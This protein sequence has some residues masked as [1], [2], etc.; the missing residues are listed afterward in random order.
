MTVSSRPGPKRLVPVLSLAFVALFAAACASASTQTLGGSALVVAA[1]PTAG[2]VPV[3]LSLATPAPAATQ[4]TV[5]SV[6][7]GALALQDQ[8]VSVIAAVKPSVVQIETA[9]GLGSGVIYDSNG[10]IVTNAHVVGSATAFKVTRSSGKTYP[11]KLV[12]TYLPD[13]IAVIRISAAGLVPAAFGDSSALAVGDFVLAIGNPL[14]LGSSVT[15]GIV[16]ALNRQVSE[17]NGYALPDVIQTS[18]AINPGNS[19]GALVDLA[20]HVV[21]IPTLAATD[22]QIGG[23]APGIGFAISSNRARSIADQLIS[24]GKVTSSGRAYLGIQLQDATTGGALVYAVTAGG[25][26]AKAGLVAGD[27]ITALDGTT[28]QDGTTLVDLVAAHQ[29][30]DVVKLTVTHQDGSTTTVRLTLGQAPAA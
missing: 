1:S 23:S 25:P 26:A 18:A 24:T 9:D 15:E 12:G 5:V 6:N 20:G 14:G 21:G 17:P 30:G 8:Q 16:S 19:G 3:A 2:T 22:P 28:V 10:D 27:V 13:D 29:P 4:Q 11:G 7:G